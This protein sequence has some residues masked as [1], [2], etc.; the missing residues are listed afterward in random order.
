MA[1]ETLGNL[2]VR[3]GLD[4]ASFD[5]GLKNI[6]ARMQLV[7]SELKASSS[8][9]DNFGKTV[10][11]LRAKQDNLAKIYQLQGQRVQQLKKQ[12]DELVKAHG[13]ESDAALNAGK[14]LNNAIAYYNK[15]GKELDSVKQEL[16]ELEK[17]TAYQ[18]SVWGKAEKAL[19]SFQQKANRTSETLKTIGE[20]LTAK[21]SA[22]LA[23]L[24]GFALKTAVDFQ[25]SQ[26]KM[27]AALGLTAEQ[28]KELNEVAKNV[29]REG[30]GESL[31]DVTNAITRVYQTMG[32]L[33]K[34]E[35]EEVTKAAFTLSEVFDADVNESTRAAAQLMQQFGV[36]GTEAMDMITV[37][38]QRGGNYSDELLDTISEYSTQFANMGFSAEQM[39]GMLIS[40]AESGIWS[41]DKLADSVKESFLQITDGSENTKEALKELGLDYNQ[42]TSDIQSGGDKANAAFMAVMTALS[43]V[44]DEAD[45]N[46]LAIELMGTPLE[47]LGPQYQEFF[48]QAGEGMTDFQGAAKDAGKAI[49]DNL[50][51]R[52]QKDLRKLSEALLPLGEVMLNEIEPALDK[53]I[54]YIERFTEWLENLSPASRKAIVALLGIVAA[55]GPLGIAFSFI[56]K[57]I[58]SI[59]K[60]IAGGIKYFGNFKTNLT[61]TTKNADLLGKSANTTGKALQTIGTSSVKTTGKIMNFGGKI[62]GLTKNISGLS[63]IAGIARFGLGALGGPLGLLATTAIPLLIQGGTKLYKHLKEENIPAIKD[64]GDKV[65]ESTT[66]SV[67]AYKDLNDQATAQLNQLSW[68]GQTVSKEIYNNLTS[69]FSQMGN[70]IADSLKQGF[71]KSYQN[72]SSFL[73]NSKTLSQQEQQEILNNVKSK[74]NE[75]QQAV[76]EAQNRIKQILETAKNEKRALTEQ[77]K[78]EINRIQQQMMNVAVQTMSKSEQ[79]QKVILERLRQESGNI[80]A[81]QAAETVQNSLKAKNGAVKEA[82]DKYN[83]TV[84][85]IIR[86]RDQTGSISK[87]QADKLIKEAKRQRDEAIKRAEEMHQNVVDRAKKQAKG[88]V[89]E[90]DWST[91][92]VLT[93]WDKMVR[94]VAKAVNTISG[95]INWVLDKIGLDKY[96]IPTWKPKGYA[97]GTP[98]SGHPGGPA[99][100]GEKGPEL[101]YI[102]G[103]GTTLLGTQGAEFHPNLPRGTAVL[104]N[105][106]TEKVLKSYGFPGYANGIGDFFSLALS[107]A[108]KLMD[109]VWKMF[110]PSISGVGGTLKTLGDGIIS[111]LKDKS[112]DFIKKKIDDFFSFDGLSGNKN[113]QAWI[114]SAVRITGVPTSWIK[115]LVTIAM[116]ES[117]GNPRAINLWDSNAKAG[118]ASRGLMQTIPSTFNAYKLPGLDDIWNPIHNAVAAIRYIKARYG[119]VFNVPGIKNLAKGLRYVGYAKGTNYHP[120]GLA[121]VGEEGEELAYIPR[122]GLALVGVGGPTLMRLPAGTSILPH[123]E[124]KEFLRFWVPGY[125]D[126]VGDYFRSSSFTNQNTNIAEA[127]AQ[128]IVKALSESPLQ[129][130]IEN[131]TNLDSRTIARETHEIV[132]EFQEFTRQRKNRFKKG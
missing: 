35:M 12:Y 6:N 120:G 2:I 76:Q 30:F 47:D 3:V 66:K 121:M 128:S 116:K 60:L 65:S 26:G 107:G 69:T 43:K 101:A 7:R 33:P 132:T 119:T 117:G 9:F 87:Q 99:I 83:K 77:E 20:N 19:S 125:A 22:P 74:Y 16:Q 52:V 115:P 48:A 102:P 84:A 5:K 105:K 59:T 28:T 18:S 108:G 75:Q 27:Q 129:I 45:R 85:A 106:E 86:E 4:G 17:K 10:D 29:W 21:V 23:T 53:G 131:I 63:K 122:K 93:K 56:S 94:G 88:Q 73:S 8:S 112:L 13:A 114:A 24:G 95:G 64:F 91:G 36:S 39:M 90:I 58:G 49:R 123:D 50:G 38:F 55:A 78:N 72:L 111:L 54:N 110:K 103:K 127:I 96:K 98:S 109:K 104:P 80:T 61:T 37:A 32:N 42:I 89:D 14:R 67:L 41:M 46:R 100:V 81:R 82:N 126:G 113:V 40:G 124:T 31:D 51:T 1:E 70:Q 62:L 57:G 68:S 11:S 79:E 92:Q 34:K 44:S 130:L 118:R 97:K 15:L 25:K 71:D